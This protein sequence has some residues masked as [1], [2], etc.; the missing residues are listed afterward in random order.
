MMAKKSMM[1]DGE[2]SRARIL[3][4]KMTK[5]NKMRARLQIASISNKYR[6]VKNSMLAGAL[7]KAAFENAH[8]LT[9]RQVSSYRE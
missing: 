2:I 6:A 3:R 8:S 9:A 4:M 5:E 1:P 7:D